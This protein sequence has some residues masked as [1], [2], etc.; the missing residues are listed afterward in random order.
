MS[1]YK[2]HT[3]FT[4]EDNTSVPAVNQMYNGSE[5]DVLWHCLEEIGDSK[6]R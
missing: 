6:G 3:T 1:D 4:Q 5:A 2:L